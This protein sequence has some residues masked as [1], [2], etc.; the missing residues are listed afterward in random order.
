MKFKV[1]KTKVAEKE[2]KALHKEQREILNTDY[3]IIETKGIEF[4]KVRPLGDAV[5]EIKSSNLRSVFRY[6]ENQIILIGLIFQKQSQKTP[7]KE[8]II[9]KKRLK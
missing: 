8:L 1:S 9:A 3:K 4:V 5:F 6:E 2:F 7:K